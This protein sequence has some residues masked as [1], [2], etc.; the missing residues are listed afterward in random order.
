MTLRPQHVGAFLVAAALAILA[1]NAIEPVR[2]APHSVSALEFARVIIG[3]PVVLFAPA[4]FFVPALFR[5]DVNAGGKLDLGW[6]LVTAAGVNLLVHV[7]HFNVLRLVGAPIEWP[8]LAGLASIES[9]AGFL[10]LRAR[11][12]D[13]EFA[14]V[15]P[16]LKRA[17]LA[18]AVLV[19]GFA[20]WTSPHLLRDGS[21]YFFNTQLD[22]DWAETRDRTA[23]VAAWDD[24]SGLRDGEIVEGVPRRRGVII[25]NRSSVPEFVPVLIAVHTRVGSTVR[26]AAGGHVIQVEQIANLAPLGTDG[27]LVERYWEWGTAA[28]AAVLEAPAGA[29][30]EL[31]LTVDPPE[32][33]PDMPDGDVAL[34]AW[35]KMSRREMTDDMKRRGHHHMHPYQLLN[36]TENIRW[37]HEVAGDYVLAGRAPDGSSSL[38]QPPAWTYLYAPSRELGSDQTVSAAVLF[39]A[40]LFGIPFVGLL[41]IRDE[42][43]TVPSPL[44]GVALGLGALQHGR[45]MAADG[46]LNFPDNLYA[47][48]LVIAVVTL[49]SG[50]TRIFVLWAVL[51]AVLRYPGAVVV[52]LAGFTYLA[53]DRE[54]R[55]KAAHALIRFGFFLALFCGVMLMVGILTRSLDTWFFALY[56]ETIPEHFDNNPDALPLLQRPL[57][58]MKLWFFFGA[59]I[60]FVAPNFQG[61]LSKVALGTAL[62]YAPFLAFIDHFSH[63]YFLPLIGLAGLAACAS[64]AQQDEERPWMKYA[65]VAV[66]LAVAVYAA[67]Q[68]L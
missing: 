20:V 45:M 18:V 14:A 7:V 47:L 37:A 10:F 50:R 9:V 33:M 28:V 57:L 39:L 53:L 58:F 22:A 62:L 54:R 17:T 42:S 55:R 15:D 41:G 61:R 16:G 6:A 21:W 67:A 3:L 11:H 25:E 64:I 5:K 59:A 52:A 26:L 29:R 65:A 44:L 23:V 60:L 19:L 48:A 51:A 40:I 31:Q 4:F 43:G 34:V 2:P 13:L 56:F 24:G 32:Y 36:V 66:A 46:S 68:T 30:L 12:G 63:H 8:A 1:L 27:P 49:V 35:S 38:H